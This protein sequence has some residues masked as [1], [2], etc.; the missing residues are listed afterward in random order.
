[1][2]VRLYFCAVLVA[3]MVAAGCN[4]QDE[5]SRLSAAMPVKGTEKP[6]AV[7]PAESDK[8][9]DHGNAAAQRGGS[10][11]AGTGEPNS[12]PR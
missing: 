6:A 2:G 10:P 8:D 5:E 3:I 12:S 11:H 7:V 9:K 4:K 1:M